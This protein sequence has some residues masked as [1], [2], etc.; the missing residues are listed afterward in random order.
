MPTVDMGIEELEKYNGTNPRPADFDSYWETAISEM[1][2]IDPDEEYVPADFKAPG[3]ECYDFYFTGANGARIHAKHIRP[4]NVTGKIPAV[5]MFHGYACSSGDWYSKL[6]YAMAGFAVYALDVRGQG[7]SSEDVGG[8]TGN[9]LYGHIIRGINEKDPHKL[10]FRDIFLDVAQLAGLVIDTEFVDETRVYARGNSQ[11]G[12]LTVVCAA[13][14]PRIS[15]IYTVYPFL[16]DYKRVWDLDLD[17]GWYAELREHFK[18]IDPRHKRE[19][20]IFTR[21]GYIDIQYLAPR[22]KAKTV[23]ATGLLDTTCPPSTQFAIFNKLTCEKEII[24][25]PDFGHEALP[26]TEDDMFAFFLEE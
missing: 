18:R 10:L 15:K 25:Y 14:E 22:I 19:N 16:S 26:D 21:L 17:A 6:P 23:M 4:A 7:G 5:L 9:T 2:A 13:L 8:V 12:A 20:E 3:V 11:G 24:F 1:K